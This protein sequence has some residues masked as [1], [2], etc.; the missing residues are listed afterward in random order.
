MEVSH[1]TSA[2]EPAPVSV[3]VT[4]L[5]EARTIRPLLDS[6]LH[7][8]VPPA[9]IVVADAGST[10]GTPDIIRAYAEQ[11]APVRLLVIPGANRAQ[12]RNAAVRAATYELIAGTDAGCQ[13]SPQWLSEIVGPMLVD[14][15]V[16][17]VA[18][19]TH[20]QAHS[21]FEAV[22]AALFYSDPP[23]LDRWLPSSRS[24]AF[25]RSAWQAAGGY[26]E[27]MRWN[28]D[29]VF[30]LA[31]RRLGATL[32]VAPYAIVHW[33]PRRN[34]AALFHQFFNE[35]RG[36]GQDRIFPLHYGRK[37]VW[38][39]SGLV[40]L[41]GGSQFWPLWALLVLAMTAFLI[42]RMRPVLRLVSS[43]SGRL[44]APAQIITADVASI[45][46]YLVGLLEGAPPGRPAGAP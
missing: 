33:R 31:L 2:R 18:G 35:A 43:S 29:T 8:A 6:L 30:D 10:D 15:E 19:H 24:I 9:E 23:S 17:A 38:Y 42:R 21:L 3:I 4:V 5:N 44:Q 13:V 32:A 36:E 34:M 25:R 45:L 27:N 41:W 39:V 46:G 11:G 22:S 12:G 26:P 28:E 40:L 37:A 1:T 16:V 14:P 20:A 7:Q